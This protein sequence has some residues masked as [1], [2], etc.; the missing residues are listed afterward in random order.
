MLTIIIR[1]VIVYILVIVAVRLMGKRQVSDM[2]TS[3]LVITLII[4]E[5]ASLPLENPSRPLMMS[6]VPVMLLI[7]LELC[8]SI[9]MLKSRRFRGIVCGHPIVVIKDGRMIKSELRRL[10][11]SEEDVYSLLRQQQVFDTESI[12]YAII[13]PNGSISVL[14]QED[15]DDTVESTEL[16]DEIESVEK[17]GENT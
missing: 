16:I 1:T 5:I 9:I 3:E 6:A 13:E 7:A 8:V 11:V 4:S 2:Q 15:R 14:M 17:G 12:R 10:R